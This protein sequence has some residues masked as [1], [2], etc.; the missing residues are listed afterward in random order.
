MKNDYN[1][2]TYK[3]ENEI[4]IV[5]IFDVH[6]GAEN[7]DEKNWKR[8]KNF[9]LNTPNVY[10]VWGGDISENQTKNS[11]NPFGNTVRP[12]EQ[13]QWYKQQLSAVRHA[14]C[15]CQEADG[16]HRAIVAVDR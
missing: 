10:C 1:I 6:Y 16:Q 12:F 15:V 13:V 2:L 3:F 14:E 9:I 8:T 5:P 7:F 4:M 11:H